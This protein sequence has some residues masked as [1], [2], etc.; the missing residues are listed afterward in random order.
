MRHCGLVEFEK[1]VPF[2][3]LVMFELGVVLL[4][5]EKGGEVEFKAAPAAAAA[6]T[7]ASAERLRL[8]Y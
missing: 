6:A 5:L 3:E 1:V 8:K 4:K 2:T 7:A